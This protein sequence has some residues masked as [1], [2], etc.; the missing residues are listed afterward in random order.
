MKMYQII[1][2]VKRNQTIAVLSKRDE[3]NMCKRIF[4]GPAKGIKKNKKLYKA[5]VI[6]I[7]DT[8]KEIIIEI[9]YANEVRKYFSKKNKEK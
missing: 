2:L 5:R 8:G 9:L 4:T 1:K 3:N 7:S 6:G